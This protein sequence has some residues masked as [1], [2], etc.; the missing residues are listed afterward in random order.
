MTGQIVSADGGANIVNTV[1]PSGGDG[2]ILR[3]A[4]ATR[5]PPLRAARFFMLR[6]ED[7]LSPA[8][9]R[10]F[11][12]YRQEGG[13]LEFMI[14]VMGQGTR[15]LAESAPGTKLRVVGPLGNGWP[16][17]EGGGAPWVKLAGGIGSAPF[18]MAIEQALAGMDEKRACKPSELVYLYG[19]AKADLLYELDAFQKL[20]VPV[21]TCTM[22]GS[23]GKKG[24]VLA[25]LEEL[26]SAGKLPKKVR[27]L[28]CGPEKMLEAVELHA[29]KHALE[30]WLSLETLMGCGVGICNGCPVPT[31]PEGPMGSWPNAKCCVEGPVFKTDA[32]TLCGAH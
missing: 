17:L 14:K 20:G 21:H 13:E 3:L 4:T 15:A 2:V 31:L 30:C 5:L 18:F 9:P 10:P 16:T 28:A 19:A 8:I 24:H 27:L 12:V 6:R 25:L 11:S 1:R 29:R 32:I 7:R 26:Q 23:A 22:D